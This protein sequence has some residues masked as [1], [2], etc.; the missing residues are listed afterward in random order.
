MSQQE[1]QRVEVIALRRAGKISQAEAA[2]RLSVSVRQVRRLEVKVAKDG[3]K[4]L[5]SARRGHPSNHR[6]GQPL[7]NQVTELIRAHYRDFGPTL[8]AEYLQE[9]HDIALSKETVRQ[10]MI[11]ERLWR[12]QRGRQARIYALRERRARFGE[13]IQV[14]GSSHA[15]FEDR[16]PRCC[17]LVFIDD[18]TSCITQ[19]RFVEQ[20][21]TLGY[22]AALYGHVQQ[23]GLWSKTLMSTRSSAAFSADVSNS[24]ARLGS[25][26]PEGCPPCQT[27]CRVDRNDQPGGAVGRE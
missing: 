4:G 1:L 18:A 10:L 3:A 27:G 22:M 23:Y 25:T 12:P 21:C 20:E 6:I 9:H 19:L 2:R 13:L 15:W 16:G 26:I 8:A 14:D 17:L 24:S 11:A 5:R 7:R